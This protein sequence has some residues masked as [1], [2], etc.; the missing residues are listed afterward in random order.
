M[1]MYVY[2]MLYLTWLGIG[3]LCSGRWSTSS[4]IPFRARVLKRHSLKRNR[5][6]RQKLKVIENERM[7]EQIYKNYENK[8]WEYA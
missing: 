3:T 2:I 8:Q 5:N 4:G 7:G 6:S 1:K